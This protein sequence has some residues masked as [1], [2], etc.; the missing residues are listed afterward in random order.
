MNELRLQRKLIEKAKAEG[1]FAMKMSHKFMIGVPD[2]IIQLP[3]HP[4]AF[5]EVKIL[6]YKNWPEQVRLKMTAQQRKFLKRLQK[7]G[8]LA[9]WIVGIEH[10]AGLSYCAGNNTAVDIFDPD[11]RLLQDG[12]TWSEVIRALEYK[13]ND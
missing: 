8:G 7:A 6:K 1:G 4:T 2:L 3:H 11:K 9:G 12:W 13:T 5:V 10:L